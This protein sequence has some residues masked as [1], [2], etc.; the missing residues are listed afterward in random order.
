MDEF[1]NLKDDNET[2][3]E[4][5]VA[6]VREEATVRVGEEVGVDVSGE[7]TEHRVGAGGEEVILVI[8]LR[9]SPTRDLDLLRLALQEAARR[10]LIP[11]LIPQWSWP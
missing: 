3:D 10:R 4:E 6:K 7:A 2:E 8:L 1:L 9:V 11:H 5:G